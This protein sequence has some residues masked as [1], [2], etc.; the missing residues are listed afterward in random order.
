[1]KTLLILIISILVTGSIFAGDVNKEEIKK[2][3]SFSNFLDNHKLWVDLGLGGGSEEKF[4]GIMG[5]TSINFVHKNIAIKL[6]LS[7]ATDGLH[8]GDSDSSSEGVSNMSILGGMQ[9]YSKK[10]T[11]IS[12]LGGIGMMNYT[13]NP[14]Y[15]D[16]EEYHTEDSIS[17]PLEV[18]F[19]TD[20]TYVGIGV[21]LFANISKN[22]STAGIILK[23]AIGKM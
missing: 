18:E 23:L 2:E 7:S 8:I 14:G 5:Y 3:S 12:L 17:L 16:D 10:Y 4:Y 13:Y 15:D 6:R 22:H 19:L 9:I 1:M 11:S 21:S 20:L